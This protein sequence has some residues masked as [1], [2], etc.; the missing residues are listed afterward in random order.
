[1]CL[2]LASFLSCAHT[3]SF[4]IEMLSYVG[5]V[6][7]YIQNVMRLVNVELGEMQVYPC[8]L[9][10]VLT[11][12]AVCRLQGQVRPFLVPKALS[13]QLSIIVRQY[14]YV[15]II[16]TVSMCSMNIITRSTQILCPKWG[17]L[18]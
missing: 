14:N 11:C 2:Y 6:T 16:P 10:R 3:C 9:K 7:T 18:D 5:M 1:M 17:S 12:A 15:G 4:T 8:I 13:P